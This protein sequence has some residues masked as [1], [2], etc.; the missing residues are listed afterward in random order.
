MLRQLRLSFDMTPAN[1]DETPRDDEV[2]EAYVERLAREKARAAWETLEAPDA[3]VLAA[4][5]AVVLDGRILGKPADEADAARMLTSL[6]GRRH[7]VLTAIAVRTAAREEV[8]I[9]QTDVAF[10]PLR[11]DEIADYWRTGEPAGKAGGYAIQ[12]LGALFV[13]DI[14]GSY[15]GVVGLPLFETAQLLARFGY[16]LLTP[17]D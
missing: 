17:K 11:P 12:G 15:S 6:S 13:R 14:R 7:D 16:R 2:P 3:P 1:I 5:T 8:A 9:S 4:D 10:R